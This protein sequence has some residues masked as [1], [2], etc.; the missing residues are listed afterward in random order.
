MLRKERAG[1]FHSGRTMN[2][3]TEILHNWRVTTDARGVAL[4]IARQMGGDVRAIEDSSHG[5]WEV[6]TDSPAAEIL[7]SEV[8]DGDVAFSLPG[9]EGIGAFSF[10]SN[11]WNPEEISQLPNGRDSFS[12]ECEMALKPV[13]FKTRTGLT[14]LYVLPSIKLLTSNR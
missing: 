3:R 14:V 12:V 6:L 9:G 10:C 8:T 7:V 13:E 11:M 1:Y 4:A 5:R 2:G